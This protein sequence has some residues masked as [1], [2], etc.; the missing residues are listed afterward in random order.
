[1]GSVAHS[2]ENSSINCTLWRDSASY[3]IS[4]SFDLKC[5][6]YAAFLFGI[7]SIVIPLQQMGTEFFSIVHCRI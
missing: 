7:C 5:P 1:M 6:L 2:A 3:L 4:S